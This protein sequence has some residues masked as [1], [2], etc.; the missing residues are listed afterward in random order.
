MSGVEIVGFVLAAL[1]LAI[2]A[3]EHYQD[4]LDPLRDYLRYD[5]TLKSLRTRLRIQQDLFEGTL[6]CLLLEELSPLQARA[7]FPDAGQHVNR[8]QWN[9]PEIDQKLQNRLG[10][11][12]ENFM[13]VVREMEMA[14]RRLMKKLDIDIEDRVGTAQSRQTHC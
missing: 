14:M 9:T 11:K 6:K 1:P 12:Y 2:S 3:I 10:G 8:T 7:L 5:S 13:D 4:G